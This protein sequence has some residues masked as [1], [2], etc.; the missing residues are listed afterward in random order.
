MSRTAKEL[1]QSLVMTLAATLFSSISTTIAEDQLPSAPSQTD[2]APPSPICTMGPDISPYFKSIRKKIAEQRKDL[3]SAE[4]A[5]VIEFKLHHNGSVSHIRL[6][7][8]SGNKAI[9]K[10][11]MKQLGKMQFDHFPKW[12]SE[13]N[14]GTAFTMRVN[15]YTGQTPRQ[16]RSYQ[17]DST[18]YLKS[19]S[20]SSSISTRG[21]LMNP[22]FK[23]IRGQIAKAWK[24][25]NQAVPVIE[26]KLLPDGR[27]A[28]IRIIETSG[29]PTLD[30]ASIKELANVHFEPFPVSSPERK[31]GVSLTMRANLRTGLDP[32][33]H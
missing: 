30:N 6:L 3:K 23:R 13:R 8:S 16:F 1:Y 31:H 12:F 15:M 11:S 4:T 18:K 33:Q 20:M 17:T 24:F 22:Y 25:G 10:A 21:P 7:Q 14:K 9:D 19:A 32:S 26:F 29:N 5:P 28:D 27:V 2:A